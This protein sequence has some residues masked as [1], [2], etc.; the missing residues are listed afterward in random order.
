MFRNYLTTAWRN[1]LRY[2]SQAIINIVGLSLA[3]G[4]NLLA[5]QFVTYELTSD[6]F[7]EHVDRIYRVVREDEAG[8][9]PQIMDLDIGIKLAEDY[10]GFESFVRTRGTRLFLKA[11]DDL[12]EEDVLF[13][14][15]SLL[16][17]FTFPLLS[18]DEESALRNVD[19]ALLSSEVALRHFGTLDVV[20]RQI[21]VATE[22]W[23]KGSRGFWRP[24]YDQEHVFTVAGVLDRI[25]GNSSLVFDVLLPYEAAAGMDIWGFPHLFAFLEE[26][27]DAGDFPSGFPRFVEAEMGADP[28]SQRLVL[29]PYAEIHFDAST[30]GLVLARTGR[31]V[32][33]SILSAI[34]VLILAVAC[35][36]YGN[37]S[38]ARFATRAREIGVRKAVGAQRSQLA[39]QFWGEAMATSA[40]A[41]GLGLVLARSGLPVLNQI[42][43][44]DLNLEFDYLSPGFVIGLLS[45]TA[46][47]GLLAGVVPALVLS[48]L[49]TSAILTSRH[50]LGAKSTFSRRSGRCPAGPLR[51]PGDRRGP[52]DQAGRFHAPQGPGLRR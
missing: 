12:L 6:R 8:R 1:L 34:G 29:Q 18:G 42:V 47:T 3:I 7:H 30:A 46:V 4:W 22:D 23:Q 44:R 15:P 50:S 27:V 43:G 51:V 24:T 45:V 48:N 19:E 16:E 9:S 21:A 26:G 37:L 17:V 52:R 5:Q 11:G 38:I 10:P 31:P 33:L 35:I 25:P 36:N 20:G 41:L 2:P 13:A 28:A 40:L 49:R 39:A 14:D 32:F